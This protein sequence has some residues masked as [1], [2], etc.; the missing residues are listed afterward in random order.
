MTPLTEDAPALSLLQELEATDLA[1]YRAVATSPTP[2]LDRLTRQLSQAANNSVL[3]FAI[4]AALATVPGAPRRAAV[5]GAVSIGITSAA[6]NVAL[7]P[8]LPR[9]RPDRL[10]ASVPFARHVRMP[11]STSFPSGHSASAFAFATAV[12]D[13]LP[14]LALPLR[15]LATSVGYSRVHCG[16]HYPGDVALGASIGAVL[17]SLTSR[18]ARRWSAP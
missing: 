4:A 12:G 18:G 11:L 5:V 1:V 9:P 3:W 17:G 16:V 15:L 6:V 7:K 10:A 2:R 8:V 13:E 14:W